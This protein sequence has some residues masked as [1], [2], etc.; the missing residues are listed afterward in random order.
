MNKAQRAVAMK[1]KCIAPNEIED[2]DLLA[3]MDGEAT[4]A[5]AA[6][7]AA[8][9]FCQQELEAFLQVDFLLRQA[10]YRRACPESDVL[11][12]YA[13]HQLEQA[14]MQSLSPHV[15]RC[16]YCQQ[17]LRQLAAAVFVSPGPMPQAKSSAAPY[18]GRIQGAGKQ[19]LRA[20]IQPPLQPAAA[21]R[22]QTEDQNIYRVGA[23]QIILSK[24]TAITTANVWQIEGQIINEQAPHTPMSGNIVLLRD[25]DI[26]ARTEV[27]EVG[28]FELI[29]VTS[30]QYNMYIDLANVLLFISDLTVP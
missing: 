10:A 23:Y 6:H 15:A 24:E 14:Q 22:G 25:D 2:I 8:C 3:Y 11:W 1:V 28:Y 12:Q 7:I 17:D 29:N 30:G 19:I 21:L 4:P 18:L 5:V 9:R 13:N 20:I 27:D 26:V 16:A